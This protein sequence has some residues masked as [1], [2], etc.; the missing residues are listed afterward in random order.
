MNINS[1]AVRQNL[2]DA[3]CNDNEITHFL[4]S[5]TPR[6]R[7]QILYDQRKKLVN[8]YHDSARKLDC[9]DFLIYQLK[10]ENDG[11]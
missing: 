7:L 5:S 9:L 10:K 1:N 6:E 8:E 3:G 4:E 11:C 2:I